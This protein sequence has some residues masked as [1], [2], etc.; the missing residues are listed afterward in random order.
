MRTL[1]GIAGDGHL[2]TG[3]CLTSVAN[4]TEFMLNGG[5]HIVVSGN[6]PC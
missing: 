6:G 1:I 5:P 3:N 2:I 4:V